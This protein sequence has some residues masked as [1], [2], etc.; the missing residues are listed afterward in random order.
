[1]NLN[2]L[3]LG[4]KMSELRKRL[5]DAIENGNLN[6]V[7]NITKLKPSIINEKDSNGFTP[8]HDAIM[9][10]HIEI[11][12][13]LIDR[14]PDV[15]A[16]NDF[17]F[18]SLHIVN[19]VS[20]NP[21]YNSE[22]ALEFSK[23]LIEK[24]ANPNLLNIYGDSPL[25]TVVNPKIA[26]LLISANANIE[27]EDDDK[28]TPLHCAKNSKIAEVLIKN[29]AEINKV[30][31]R[32][33]TPLY[34]AA[35]RGLGDV[36]ELLTEKGASNQPNYYGITPHKVAKMSL[37][38]SAYTYYLLKD[39]NKKIESKLSEIEIAAVKKFSKDIVKYSATTATISQCSIINAIL[40]GDKGYGGWLSEIMKTGSLIHNISF[41]ICQKI[42][43]IKVLEGRTIEYDIKKF[44]KK[45][46]EAEKNDSLRTLEDDTNFKK[47]IN[48]G[49]KTPNDLS[50]R[51]YRYFSEGI[52]LEKSLVRTLF[53]ENIDSLRF[54]LEKSQPPI[55]TLNKAFNYAHN[56]RYG[57]PYIQYNKTRPILTLY[58]MSKK[59][60]MLENY[61]LENYNIEASKSKDI[62]NIQRIANRKFSKC[63]EK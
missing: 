17:G 2:F 34:C 52:T 50:N 54:L 58:Q 14:N 6:D 27:A 56:S 9:F 62:E 24:K 30:N 44:I 37:A 57:N 23:L 3:Y 51:D 29:R 31:I 63:M 45:V 19:H 5:H 7:K 42:N 53:E 49:Y 16:Q 8:L 21:T 35:H 1:M 46:N 36:V 20:K 10:G 28:N 32:G 13:E 59:E 40:E 33:E 41:D 60:Q 43:E 11:G 55:E 15:N 38:N 12:R 47:L 22:I 61:N 48:D 39:I 18:T 4:E 25:H 26:E